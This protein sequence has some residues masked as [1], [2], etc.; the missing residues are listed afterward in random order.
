MNFKAGK[1]MDKLTK[2]LILIE[3][4]EINFDIVKNYINDNPLR[5]SSL[6][7]LFL[8]ASIRTSS[9]VKYEELEP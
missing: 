5:F 2:R 6:K 7:R 3:L 9:E 1:A 8:G 4:N